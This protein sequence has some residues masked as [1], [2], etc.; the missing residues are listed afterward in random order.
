M[1]RPA[2]TIEC[3]PIVVDGVM[4]ITTPMLQ[5]QALDAAT[6]KLL[7]TFDP[8]AGSRLRGAPGVNRGVTFWEDPGNAKDRRIFAAS[9]TVSSA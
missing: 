9:A 1:E 2:T 4:Y 8:Y 3:T 7:W 6:G 5:V